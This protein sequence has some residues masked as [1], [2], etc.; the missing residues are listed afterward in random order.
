M[1]WGLTAFATKACTIMSFFEKNFCSG[2]WFYL[3]IGSG[4]HISIL[5][6]YK[7]IFL[8]QEW[9]SASAFLSRWESWEQR[10]DKNG[11][12]V[13][14]FLLGS[15]RQIGEEISLTYQ[16]SNAMYTRLRPVF[17][18]LWELHKRYRKDGTEYYR[19]VVFCDLKAADELAYQ[20]SVMFIATGCCST[21][22]AKDGQIIPLREA[23]VNQP[24]PQ[25]GCTRPAGCLCTYGIFGDRDADGNLIM[26]PSSR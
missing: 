21:C 7:A 22:E 14:E 3:I 16:G 9:L 6:Q 26:K 13:F 23:V 1:S 11:Q 5:D 24:I 12:D 25:N 15:M 4:M 2:T 10:T 19:Q 17:F 18:Y 8:E 20:Q